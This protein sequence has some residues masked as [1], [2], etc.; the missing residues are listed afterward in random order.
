MH[1]KVLTKKTFFK[2]IL[3]A[4]TLLIITPSTLLYATETRYVSDFLIVNIKDSIEA[5]YTVVGTVQSDQKL[6]VL[7]KKG[8]YIKIRTE[9]NKEGWVLNQYLKS[10]IPKKETIANQKL[11]IEELLEKIQ[12]Y[13][14]QGSTLPIANN[15]DKDEIKLLKFKLAEL[16]KVHQSLQNDY[17]SIL[18]NPPKDDELLSRT[19]KEF[20]EKL[21]LLEEENKKLQLARQEQPLQQSSN[22]ADKELQKLKLQYTNLLQSSENIG[23]ITEDRDAL[24]ESSEKSEQLIQTLQTENKDLLNKQRIYWFL[25]GAVVFTFGLLFGKI[26]TKKKNRFSY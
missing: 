6:E 15:N 11:E 13:E 24:L 26:G 20:Q 14:N 17:H 8:K 5:P 16:S 10:S 3:L 9:G 21:V 12:Q 2:N 19:V 4:S 1:Y 23:S 25:A 18:D 22:L 7:E